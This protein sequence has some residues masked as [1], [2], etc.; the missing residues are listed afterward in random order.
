MAL[1]VTGRPPS[2]NASLWCKIQSRTMEHYATMRKREVQRSQTQRRTEV[3][4]MLGLFCFLISVPAT[5]VHSLFV[6]FHQGGHLLFMT[7]SVS[8]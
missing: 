1:Q 8:I 7:C 4:G 6:K 3:S 5:Q 2:A